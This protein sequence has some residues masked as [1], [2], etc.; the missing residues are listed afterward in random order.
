MTKAAEATTAYERA[1]EYR[2]SVAAKLKALEEGQ[3]SLQQQAA[4]VAAEM[5]T[6]AGLLS[7]D[8]NRGK[9][10]KE[11][12]ADLAAIE[13]QIGAIE[14]AGGLS[15]ILQQ[16]PRMSELAEAVYT[17]NLAA[18]EEMKAKSEDLKAEIRQQLEHFHEIEARVLDHTAIVESLESE[19]NAIKPFVSSV[20]LPEKSRYRHKGADLP[21]SYSLVFSDVQKALKNLSREGV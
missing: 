19:I 20:D 9:E 16:D 21:R 18:L 4:S 6:A 8:G 11:F 10:L 13:Q 7:A 5:T 17:E 3:A 12:R 15:G 14:E 2:Q 1:Q